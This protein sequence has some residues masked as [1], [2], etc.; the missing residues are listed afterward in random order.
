MP[1]RSKTCRAVVV[2][3][4]AL[5]PGGVCAEGIDTEHLFGFMI[6]TDVG[7]VGERELQSQTNGR[8][9]RNGGTYRAVGQEF[10][11]EFVPVKN[12]RV[13]LGTT[14]ASH[15]IR[16]VPGFEDRRQ[17]SWEGVSIDLR[18]RFLERDAAPFGFTFAVENH[19]SRVDE[20]T[21][22]AVRSYG[23]EF[24]AG[25]RPRAYSKR[26][27][28]RPQSDLPAGMDAHHRDRRRRAGIHHRRRAGPDGA[29]ATGLLSRR[30]SALSAAI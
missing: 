5:L 1:I 7:N 15:Y 28:R 25:V 11:L 6:G 4:S 29:M 26:C 14:F 2:C 30:G 24:T 22:A 10:E 17:S 12:F 16:G 21:A 23:T 18:Y 9:A 20:T 8:F 13:E 3:L 19:A 27:R